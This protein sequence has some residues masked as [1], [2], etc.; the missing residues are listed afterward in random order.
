MPYPGKCMPLGLLLT[1]LTSKILSIGCGWAC[2]ACNTSMQYSWLSSCDVLVDTLQ[3]LCRPG[4]TGT[5]HSMVRVPY[6]YIS[7]TYMTMLCI[8]PSCMCAPATTQLATLCKFTW[9]C[10]HGLKSMPI[11]PV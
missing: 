4:K 1:L 7:T 11:M 10:I 6:A 5:R 2:S 8:K 3:Y 9:K